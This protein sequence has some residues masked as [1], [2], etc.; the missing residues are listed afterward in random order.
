MSKPLIPLLVVVVLVV[1]A[2]ATNPSPD[3]HREKIKAAV[4]E[5]SQLESVLGVGHIAAFASKYHSLGLAS[6]TT[7][8]DK[9][10]SV[11]VLG[12]VFV[13]D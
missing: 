4:A 2:F 11:G 9:L 6:Y 1:A 8:N 13:A 12:M 7:V 5:R 10:R 3:R